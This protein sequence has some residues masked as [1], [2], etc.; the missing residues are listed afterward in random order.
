MKALRRIWAVIK[1]ET[2]HITRDKVMLMICFLAPIF[3]TV[4][5]GFVYINQK[6]INLHEGLVVK[7]DS[8]EKI[9]N[10]NGSKI[11]IV[12][13]NK[14]NLKV[15]DKILKIYN[16]SN[17]L[18]ESG[19]EAIDLIKNG[20][21][22]DLILMDDMMPRMSGVETLQKIKVEIP[23]FDIPVIALTANALTGMREKYLADGFNDYLAKP[24]NKDELNRVINE[25][26]NKK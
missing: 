17:I 6:I 1:K 21:K 15:A 10:Y 25:Y 19:V 8:E 9:L 23:E 4:L 16:T 13:D 14:L 18:V 26:L 3:L 5:F 22:F 11:L 2:L 24:I 7:D 20:N 12:D